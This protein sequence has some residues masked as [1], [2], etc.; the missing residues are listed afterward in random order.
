MMR[1]RSASS[2]F[3][4]ARQLE[5]L[6]SVR[7][8]SSTSPPPPPHDQEVP[9]GFKQVKR[10]E[11]Q[12][13]VD[14]VFSRVAEGYDKM[15]DAMS[16]GV[17]RLWKDEFV[18]MLG[19]GPGI[20]L[21]DLAGGTGDISFRVVE[22]VR[23]AK[24]RSHAKQVMP[25]EVIL[26]DINPNMLRVGEERAR[27][28]GYLAENADPKL[29]VMEINAQQ[30]N[31]PD[32][33][34]DCVTMAFGIRNCTDV[35]QVL[36]EAHRV[37]KNGGRFMC[38]EFSEVKTPGLRELYDLYSFNVIPR[39]GQAIS[40]DYDSYQYLVESIRRFPSQDVFADMF[41]EA[42]FQHVGYTNFVFGVA[43]IHS[44]FKFETKN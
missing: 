8:F 22:A 4:V 3:G 10:E 26:S 9:F 44:G 21:L 38:L 29:T 2:V 35:P 19:P 17:H 42:G 20:R 33:S 43:A 1:L 34:V 36:R 24:S 37:L 27:K 32:N 23:A 16:V 18:R 31:L 12:K 5:T 39:L 14:D 15:N 28:L 30:I 7:A 11:K 6:S 40:G 41:R 25:S 13:H